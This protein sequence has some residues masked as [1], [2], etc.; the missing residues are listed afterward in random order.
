MR[1]SDWSSDVCSSDLR[2]RLAAS[3]GA[4]Y[5]APRD[6]LRRPAHK[7][8]RNL[9]PAA[10]K[11]THRGEQSAGRHARIRKFPAEGSCANAH[12]YALPPVQLARPRGFSSLHQHRGPPGVVTQFERVKI[13]RELEQRHGHRT[14]KTTT[15]P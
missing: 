8:R 1:I 3:E 4:R 15:T 10:D 6:R 11:Q 9:R 2:W 5:G 14:T 12:R 7:F 13:A